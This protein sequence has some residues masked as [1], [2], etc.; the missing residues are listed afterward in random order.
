MSVTANFFWHGPGLRL[1]E[2]ACLT[3]FVQAGV[4]VH[5]HTF[6]DRLAVPER[7]SRSR[8]TAACS[9]TLTRIWCTCA[10]D[11]TGAGDAFVGAFPCPGDLPIS[12]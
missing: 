3:S 10:V 12:A 1:Y 7:S 11:T 5:L 2:R 4:T 9:R 6:D 8:S